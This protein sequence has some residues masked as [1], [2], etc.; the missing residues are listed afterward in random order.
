MTLKK[1]DENGNVTKTQYEVKADKAELLLNEEKLSN[2]SVVQINPDQLVNL[3]AWDFFGVAGCNFI[4][5]AMDECDSLIPI[6]T[7]NEIEGMLLAFPDYLDD[8][9]FDTDYFLIFTEADAEFDIS[10]QEQ[11]SELEKFVNSDVHSF[12][13]SHYL[14]K[15]IEPQFSLQ[16]Y[17]LFRAFDKVWSSTLFI[18][19]SKIKEFEKAKMKANQQAQQANASTVKAPDIIAKYTH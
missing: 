12:L 18:A 2:G 14:I 19:T 17:A 11:V 9:N 8:P 6:I 4:H 10:N 13:S 15:S 1:Y 5:S 16:S 3:V 7:P